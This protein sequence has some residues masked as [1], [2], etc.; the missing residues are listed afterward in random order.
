MYTDNDDPFASSSS[1]T[2]K[3]TKTL[4]GKKNTRESLS[5]GNIFPPYKS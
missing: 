3:P 4:V 2:T 1:S 5:E